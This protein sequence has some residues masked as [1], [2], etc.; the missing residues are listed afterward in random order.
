[1]PI[2]LGAVGAERGRSSSTARLPPRDLSA[3]AEAGGLHIGGGNT[4]RL[5]DELRRAGAGAA[6][7]A[8]ASGMPIYGGGAGAAVLGRCGARSVS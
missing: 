7:T 2:F 6:L 8:L 5:L 1:M 4:F 3:L